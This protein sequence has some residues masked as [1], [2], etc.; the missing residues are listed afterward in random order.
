MYKVF[1]T[2]RNR[3]AITCKAIT[4][5]K[6]HSVIPHQ[7]YVY[8]NLT[9]YRIPEHFVY[10]AMLYEKGII[11]QVT[12]TSKESTFNCFSKGVTSNLFGLQHEQD[13]NKDSYN[14]LL[15]L[16]ND[17]IVTPGFDEILYK[18]WNDINKHKMDNI[19]V[20][21]QIPGGIK[22]IT[23]L[24]YSIGG[25]EA[26]TGK[27]GGSAFWSVRPNFFRDVGYLNLNSLLGLNKGHD[28]ETWGLLDRATKGKDYILGL[29]HKLCMHTG[30]YAGSCCNVLTRNKNLQETEKEK[31]IR[32]EKAEEEIDKMSFDEFYEKVSKDPNV[33]KD[34]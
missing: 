18:A 2:V 20:V 26:V 32:F 11:S 28:I 33:A 9:S 7:I 10:W 14:F 29:K 8:D 27:I 15:F 24:T 19:K 4:A 17:I 30:K 6:R 12:F 34:W 31:L 23:H 16:D 21:G 3:M 25:V 1:F 5:L 13:L 22:S